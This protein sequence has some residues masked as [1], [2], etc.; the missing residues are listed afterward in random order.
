[1]ERCSLSIE[2]HFINTL[3]HF[4]EVGETHARKPLTV[5]PKKATTGLS[6]ADLHSL[7]LLQNLFSS[8]FCHVRMCH[9]QGI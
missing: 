1:M 6:S 9:K 4:L 5:G 2:T 7:L 3:T 8:F